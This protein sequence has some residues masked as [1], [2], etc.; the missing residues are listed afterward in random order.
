MSDEL[1]FSWSDSITDD[2]MVEL[3]VSHR[4]RPEVG[5]WDRIR[6]HSLGWVTARTRDGVLVGF[7]NIAWD[8]G[9][10]A[11]L[12]DTKTRR[13]LAASWCCHRTGQPRRPARDNSGVRVAPRRL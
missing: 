10:H 12:L 3:V 6:P 1:V 2:E 9:D 4:G 5:W 11:F 8:G 13:R 7:V